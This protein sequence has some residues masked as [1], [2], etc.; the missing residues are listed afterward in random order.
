M[1]DALTP[2]GRYRR[3]AAKFSE[4]AQSAAHPFMRQY[5]ERLAQRHL[6]HAKNQE[7]LAKISDRFG[8]SQDDCPG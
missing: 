8:A 6:L 1:P 2:A 7:K 5:F 3:D 4:L